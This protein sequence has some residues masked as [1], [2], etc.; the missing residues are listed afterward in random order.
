MLLPRSNGVLAKTQSWGRGYIL[1]HTGGYWN[2]WHGNATGV[3]VKAVPGKTQRDRGDFQG[4]SWN[5]L[6]CARTNWDGLECGGNAREGS[7]NGRTHGTHQRR[8]QDLNI[9]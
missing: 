4:V 9:G 2:D 1:S 3:L 8:L 7:D 6:D 5:A